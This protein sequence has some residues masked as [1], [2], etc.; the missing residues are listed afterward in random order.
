MSGMS[1]GVAFK[2]GAAYVGVATL[3]NKRQK[4]FCVVGR[5]GDQISFA[6]VKDVQRETAEECDGVETAKIKSADGFDYF[7]SSRVE[8]DIDG[9]FQVVR[10]CQA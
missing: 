7:L 1:G 2:K 6:H 9:A 4:V 10:M 3:D 5:R 8:V